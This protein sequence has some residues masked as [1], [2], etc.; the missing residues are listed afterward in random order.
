MAANMM[1]GSPV[2]VARPVGTPARPS[3]SQNILDIGIAEA[4]LNRVFD[5]FLSTQDV[6]CEL[7]RVFADGQEKLVGRTATHMQGNKNPVWQENFMFSCLD[8]VAIKFRVK[9][10]K[11]FLPHVFAGEAV[12]DLRTVMSQMQSG[13][14]RGGRPSSVQLTKKGSP[15]GTL[16]FSVS[17]GAMPGMAGGM[18]QAV[19]IV[20]LNKRDDVFPRPAVRTPLPAK[21]PYGRIIANGSTGR[22]SAGGQSPAGAAPAQ[23]APPSP[24]S[25][26]RQLQR[27]LGRPEELEIMVTQLFRNIARPV[28]A[29][30][31]RALSY[32]DIPGLTKQLCMG[33]GVT[34]DVFG[35]MQQMYWRFVISP[36][37][38]LY[39]S[40][41]VRMIIYALRLYHERSAPQQRGGQ[42]GSSIPDRAVE[43][44][45]LVSKELGRGGQGIVY[46]ATDKSS[47]NQ[48]V[49]K[50]YSKS[51]QNAPLDEVTREFELLTALKH[52]KIARVFEIFQD[53]A[54]VY[55]VQE[56]YFGG[57]L[58]TAPSKANAAGVRF[59]ELWLARIIEQVL[60]GVNFLHQ[61][62]VIH[63]DLKEPN[64]MVTNDSDWRDPQVIV[65]DFGLAN[66]FS[67]TSGAGGTPGYMPPEVW[68][69]GLWTPRGDIFSIGVMIYTLATGENPFTQGCRSIEEVSE[70][71]QREKAVMRTGSLEIQRLVTSMISS[72]FH[73]RPVVETVLKDPWLTMEGVHHEIDT[74]VL[75]QLAGRRKQTDLYRALL[76]DVAAREN[77]AQLRDLNDVFVEL[78]K[79]NSGHISAKELRRVLEGTWSSMQ[80]DQLIQGLLGKADGEINYEDFMGQLIAAKEPEEDRLI[81]QI[82]RDLDNDG[83]GYLT[84]EDL[85]AALGRPALARVLNNR[86]PQDLMREMDQNSDGKVT[87]DEFKRAL[88]QGQYRTTT[89]AGMPR[90]RGDQVVLFYSASYSQWRKARVTQVDPASGA[91]Q[92]DCKPDYW[93]KGD[94]LRTL[95]RPVGFEFKPGDKAE[96]WSNTY[97]T[98]IPCNVVEV[99][100]GSG[101][102][103][104]DQKPGYWFRGTEL[105]TRVRLAGEKSA[106][107]E[108]K[109]KTAGL[110]KQLFNGAI[111]GFGVR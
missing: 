103:Q 56:P 96:M 61:N 55:I 57:D 86:S 100:E 99:D 15:T 20:G 43:D 76:A 77:L 78:D 51:N 22:L 52:P 67:T 64:V 42:L 29:G 45:Y 105:K 23:R 44:K 92:V 71:T 101:A 7:W 87:F 66:K 84:G 18:M 72:N 19:D 36:D 108:N 30:A 94:E 58:T 47:Q 109:A 4:Q 75:Q 34:A 17:P 73:D 1:R 97:S 81:M 91:I 33:L 8:G 41:A 31:K 6:Y 106:E 63:C 59:N 98:W 93:I 79:D 53:M 25:L 85:V 27:L 37:G 83:S 16:S 40:E 26:I 49:V 110:A 9:V 74:N 39:E 13:S 5:R 35:D 38:L 102:V 69:H 46:L 12:I 90:Y 111:D 54:N 11:I 104:V 70:K 32:E 82:F 14:F 89:K 3:A 95:V 88:Q 65:I 68:A 107:T 10:E 48:V 24:R 50:A 80:I 60:V 21:D 28:G 62:G 2:L